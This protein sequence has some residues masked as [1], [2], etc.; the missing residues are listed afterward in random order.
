[1]ILIGIVPFLFAV[2][3][4]VVGMG[5][6]A[7]CAVPW[8]MAAFFAAGAV[9]LTL[10]GVLGSN[11]LDIIG[12]AFLFVG[13]GSVGLQILGETDADWEHTPEYRGFRPL[14]GMR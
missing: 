5:L 1:M 12:A 14:A 10:A 4:I 6:Y 11:A 2:G 3:M 9:M 13:L 8:W 7:A